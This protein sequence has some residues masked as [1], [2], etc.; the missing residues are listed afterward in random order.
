MSFPYSER[1]ERDSIYSYTYI[2]EM[3]EL[4][5][6][7]ADTR[8]LR[9]YRNLFNIKGR[10]ID[11]MVVGVKKIPKIQ[12]EIYLEQYD[13]ED[14]TW[15]TIKK[16]AP[17]WIKTKKD[18]EVKLKPALEELLLVASETDFIHSHCC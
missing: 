1:L 5:I 18:L 16:T 7:R 6:E 9:E 14:G 13:Q 17:M 3:I 11:A 4:E 15:E 10:E 8:V 12:L 2:E